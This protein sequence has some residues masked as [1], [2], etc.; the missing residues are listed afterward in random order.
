MTRP[1]TALL[2]LWGDSLWR[3]ASERPLGVALVAG[4]EAL[5]ATVLQTPLP[6]LTPELYSQVHRTGERLPFERVWQ[7]RRR[8]LARAA[9]RL[10][11]DESVEAGVNTVRVQLDLTRAYPATAGHQ[12]LLRTIELDCA[13]GCLRVEDALWGQ[14]GID[15][16]SLLTTATNQLEILGLQPLQ[17]TVLHHVEPLLFQDNR[18]ENQTVWRWTWR[19]AEVAQHP[20]QS[21]PITVGYCIVVG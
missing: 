9:V 7:E 12:R 2:P 3:E 15:L 18:G 20:G 4:L 19:P 10:L 21:S 11:L 16:A 13:A 17:D 6:V 14:D 1:S 8:R 5:E